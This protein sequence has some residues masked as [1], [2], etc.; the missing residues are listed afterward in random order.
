MPKVLLMYVANGNRAGFWVKRDSWGNTCALVKLVGGQ[1]SGELSGEPPYVN[2][3]GKG[4][5]TVA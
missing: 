2:V 3:K 1:A 5:P 4:N